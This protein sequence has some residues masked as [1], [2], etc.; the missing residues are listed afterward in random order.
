MGRWRRHDRRGSSRLAVEVL[1][2]V[3]CGLALWSYSQ[4][5]AVAAG[6]GGG[7]GSGGGMQSLL[8]GLPVVH[9]VCGF[10]CVSLG[11]DLCNAVHNCSRR[12]GVPVCRCT[13]VYLCG[14]RHGVF[15]AGW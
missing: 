5:V 4:G 11:H 7:G 15:S 1:L 13:C 10:A 14:N 2:Y 9:T 8:S 6:A 3:G 12:V